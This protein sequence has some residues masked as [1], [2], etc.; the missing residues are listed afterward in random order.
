MTVFVIAFL[1]SI[2]ASKTTGKKSLIFTTIM[3]LGVLFAF[4]KVW[5][6]WEHEVVEINNNMG[7]DK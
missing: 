3:I 4:Y 7:I 6:M 5:D 2:F 1:A